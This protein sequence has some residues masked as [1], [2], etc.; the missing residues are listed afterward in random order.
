MVDLK[1]SVNDK[2]L[3]YTIYLHPELFKHDKTNYTLMFGLTIE[4]L[5]LQYDAQ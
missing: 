5:Q 2:P 4:N 3:L 1:V